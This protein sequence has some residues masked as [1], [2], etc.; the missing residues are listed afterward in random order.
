[1]DE[2]GVPKDV[3]TRLDIATKIVERAE[4]LGIPRQDVIIDCLVLTVGAERGSGRVVLEAVRFVR[5]KLGL[6]VNLGAATSPLACL[7][8]LCSTKASWPWPS[9]PG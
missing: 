4:S 1:M 5:E 3:A 8:A 2:R 6:N 7:T 9:R